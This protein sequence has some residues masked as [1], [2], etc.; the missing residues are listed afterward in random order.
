MNMSLDP[1]AVQVSAPNVPTTL[2][3]TGLSVVMM[4]DILLKTIF[5]MSVNTTRKIAAAICMPNGLTQQLI[6]QVR[7][8]GLV[9]AMGTLHA[10]SSSEM[11]LQLTDSGKAY[12]RDAL[13]Q[14][15]YY[16]S[17]PVPLRQYKQ[18]VTAQSIRNIRMTRDRL[19][20]SMDHLILPANLLDQLGPAVG[21]GRSILMYGPPGN[22]KSSIAEGI[23]SALGGN[24][25]IPNAIEYAGQ[26]I[27]VFDPIVHTPIDLSRDED[28]L[29]KRNSRLDMRYILCRRPT[30][31][32][33]GELS[34][35]MLNL[36]YN[37]SAKTYQASLQLKS[38]G[39]VFIVDDLGRQEESPQALINRWIVPM[40]QGYDILTLHSGEKFEVPFDTLVVFSTN[41]HPNRIFDVAA[42]RR[43]FFK[44]RVNGP[45]REEFIKIFWTVAKKKGL[46]LDE[47]V[48]AYILQVKYPEVGNV[49][50]SYHA[51]FL[52]DQMVAACDFEGLAYRMTPELIDRAWIN[53]YVKEAD[54]DH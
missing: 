30:V 2:A 50:A 7:D 28:T 38:S 16:G 46:D 8:A 20:A 27:T 6:D 22:G 12:A 51:P 9:Q 15:E 54:I 33:G 29:R 53:L 40:E 36:N 44:V 10:S 5:R 47:N 26:I 52:I 45:T 4:R 34:L 1:G 42:L 48:L 17:M 11:E 23:R 13:S 39:G 19:Q 3:E 32:T 35:S 21:S 41:F 37:P 24:V 31:M 43:I 25:W 18:Q 14:S 49:Y